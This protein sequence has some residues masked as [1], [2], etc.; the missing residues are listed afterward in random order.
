MRSGQG[1]TGLRP[2][3]RSRAGQSKGGLAADARAELDAGGKKETQRVEL[4]GQGVGYYVAQPQAV[5]FYPPILTGLQAA[6]PFDIIG[7][8]PVL[9][10]A[11]AKVE[12]VDAESKALR[13]TPTAASPLAPGQ[14]VALTVEQQ[15]GESDAWQEV[16]PD[17][18]NWN[19]PPQVVWTPPTEN[20][21]P[22]VTLLPDLKGEVQLEASVAGGAPGTPGPASIAFTLKEAGPDAKDATARLVLDRE[23]GGK[24]LPVDQSQRYSVLVE[25]DGHQEP[26]ADVHWPANFE[27]E[28]VK[29]EAPVLTAKQEGYTQFFRAEVGG[30]NVLWHTT[31]YRPGEFII[32]EPTPAEPNPDWVKIFSQQG[33]QQVQQ[34]RFPAGATF[35]GFKVEVH[36]PD[37]Y[38]RFVT[39]KA[40]LRTP[41][42]PSAAILT[43][44]HGKF[45]GLRPGS[46]EVT[47]EFQGMTSKVPL[48][49][50]VSAEVEIDKIVIEPG[51]KN[52]FPCGRAKRMT[53]TRSATRTASRWATSPAWAT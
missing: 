23:P 5:R 42:P 1:E 14:T 21:R 25:K 43:A 44:D 17:A 26:A 2:A 22:T 46:T 53:C 19:V 49:V 3:H 9:R 29:W 51:K 24:L 16:R 35:T 7:S 38:T 31:T 27:N 34:V 39:K 50:D 52:K 36:Y 15:V 18:V 41:E 45:L 40:Y 33:P 13:I 8:I 11:T 28:Y 30:R 10:P 48:K 6:T 4:L 32:D 37:G 12:V 20:L 47:A